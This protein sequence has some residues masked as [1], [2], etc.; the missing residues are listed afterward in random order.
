M[1]QNGHLGFI[2][3][4]DFKADPMRDQAELLDEEFRPIPAER[5]IKRDPDSKP[6]PAVVKV[7]SSASGSRQTT[8]LVEQILNRMEFR[9][10]TNR[11]GRQIGGA[12]FAD[13]LAKQ[14][15]NP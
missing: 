3:A 5:L 9:F 15:L 11:R 6:G 1:N 8:G 10:Q 12:A 13:L 7:W 2:P 4:R 14:R